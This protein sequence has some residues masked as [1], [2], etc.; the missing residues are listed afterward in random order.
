MSKH[1]VPITPELMEVV[2][3]LHVYYGDYEKMNLWLKIENPMLGHIAPSRMLR[4]PSLRRKL[5]KF[6]NT[7]LDE[8]DQQ[9]D[10]IPPTLHIYEGEKP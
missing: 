10:K 1:E 6:I 2:V 8:N 5:V 9:P 3:A 7:A 4:T